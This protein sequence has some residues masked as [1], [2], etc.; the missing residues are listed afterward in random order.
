MVSRM[1][2]SR[3]LFVT[4]L[5]LRSAPG[6]GC[7]ARGISWSKEGRS[8]EMELAGG[9]G[10]GGNGAWRAEAGRISCAGRDTGRRR[11]VATFLLM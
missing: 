3:V 1:T 9:D 7:V 2:L 6:P 4:L 11:E 8:V 10:W 5:R